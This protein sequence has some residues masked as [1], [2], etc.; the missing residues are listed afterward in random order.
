[1]PFRSIIGHRHV[2]D[3]LARAVA[4]DSLPPSLILA[5]PEGV[6]K[7]RVALALAQAL[8]C[9]SRAQPVEAAAVEATAGPASAQ[10]GAAIADACGTCPSCRRIEKGI[11]PDVL[12][13]D[14]KGIHPEVLDVEVKTTSGIIPVDVVREVVKVAGFRPYEARR[15]VIVFDPA[16]AME[17]P[18]QNALLKTLEETP[19][20]SV[21][22]LVTSRPDVLL[23][24][25]R[26]RC[27]QIRFGAL[28]VAEIAE[29]LVR[30][31]G[32]D[33]RE[34][35]AA[36]V[37]ATG[38]VARALEA[39][40]EE[41]AEARSV[42]LS[43][44]QEAAATRDAQ[45]LLEQMK[46]VLGVDKRPSG[47]TAAA[48]R[49]QLSVSL[50]ALLSL[51]RDALVM[52]VASGSA[53]S[54]VTDAELANADLK[55]DLASVAASLGRPRV[56]R[57]FRAVDRALSALDGNANPKLVIDWLAFQM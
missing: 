40:S 32:L 33:E 21:F 2:I 47:T 14:E 1:M 54:T 39:A 44:L 28:T 23:P 45:R 15:R 20:A 46:G 24:T 53:P 22:V 5:G 55:G 34:A 36:A 49:E 51:L 50:R 7:R 27:P 31:R 6:G 3:L 9:T 41:T 52:Q 48:E 13:V 18:S 16:D 56:M 42:A 4:R 38:S 26:S 25:I 19:P 17:S 37:V 30:D 35:R 8:N 29:I 43:V 57:A 11:H 12:V 10:S